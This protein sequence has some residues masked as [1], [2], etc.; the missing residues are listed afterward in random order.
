MACGT[1]VLSSTAG[2]LREVLTDASVLVDRFDADLWA[3]HAMSLLRDPVLARKGIDRSA[4]FTWERTA[5][6]TWAIYRRIAG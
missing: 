4:Q 5:A 3:G 1:P 2:S 6:E